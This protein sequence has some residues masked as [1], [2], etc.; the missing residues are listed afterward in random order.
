MSTTLYYTVSYFREKSNDKRNILFPIS[1]PEEVFELRENHF[2]FCGIL[3]TSVKAPLIVMIQLL[4][5]QSTRIFGN[6]GHPELN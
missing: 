3:E 2:E 4:L 6:P 1:L 5:I